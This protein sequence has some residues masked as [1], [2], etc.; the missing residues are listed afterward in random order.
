MVIEVLKISVLA[1]GTIMPL[2]FSTKRET[3]IKIPKNYNDTSK[4]HYAINDHG[5][6]ERIHDDDLSSHTL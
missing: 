4:A 3:K 6:L 1:V 2:F 5:Y